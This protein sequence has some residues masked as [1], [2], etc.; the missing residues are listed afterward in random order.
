MSD[1]SIIGAPQQQPQQNRSVP[2][3]ELDYQYRT[4]EPN[5]GKIDV[6]AELRS[7]LMQIS[8]GVDDDG[9]PVYT[10]ESLWGLL[11]YYTRDMRLANLST[12]NNEFDYCMYYI[13]LAGDCLREGYTE[14]FLT[15]LSRA[16]T[17]LEL[18]QSKGGF[19]RKLLN[20]FRSEQSIETIEPKKSA[21]SWGKKDNQR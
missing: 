4:T 17:I 15:S 18:S 13:D 9:N 20:T 10:P 2:I 7:K 16:V 12:F 14:S 5:W 21:M 11:G 19:F 1:A 3:S 8:E 6:P